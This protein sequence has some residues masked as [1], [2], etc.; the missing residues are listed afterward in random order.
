MKDLQMKILQPV[1]FSAL[2]LYGH[3]P[4]FRGKGRL[5]FWLLQLLKSNGPLPIRLPDQSRILL[6]QQRPEALTCLWLGMDHP[7]FAK[8]YW[9]VLCALPAGHSV[10][11]AGAHIGYYALMAAH[12]LQQAGAGVVFAFEPHPINFAD[13]Q[14]NQQLNNINNLIPIQ[15]AISDQTAKVILFSGSSSVE[16][17]L[18]QIP[19]H[20]TS[21]EVECTTLD[22]FIG[23]RSE[24]KIGLVKLDVEGAELPALYGARKLI[25]RDKPHIIYEE[26]EE[27]CRLFGYSIKDL[28]GFLESLGYKIY[29][30]VDK[31]IVKDKPFVDNALAVHKSQDLAFLSLI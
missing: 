7:K 30:I 18:K 28:R 31:S 13:L 12:R 15:S 5:L 20:S 8:V 10:I 27:R 29:P 16:P 17:S 11:D 3:I 22:D 1:F 24:A 14:R 25:E 9:Q 6:T 21:Y 26:L 2:D 4:Y 23:S 19:S